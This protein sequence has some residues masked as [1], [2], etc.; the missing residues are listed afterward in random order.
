[1]FDDEEGWS[2]KNIKAQL[3]AFVIGV[4]VL[5]GVGDLATAYDLNKLDNQL[6]GQIA[7]GLCTV[8]APCEYVVTVGCDALAGDTSWHNP[9]SS[10]VV[11][12][13]PVMIANQD[14]LRCYRHSRNTVRF[15]A[16]PGR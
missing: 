1:M 12:R 5:L 2:W 4:P 16:L 8:R 11:A 9:F 13:M 14:E 10:F 7:A 6:R 15:I 3:I